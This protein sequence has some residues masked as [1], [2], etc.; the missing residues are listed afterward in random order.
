VEKIKT[1]YKNPEEMGSNP[2]C[3]NINFKQIK[4]TGQAGDLGRY[5]SYGSLQLPIAE[6]KYMESLPPQK[7]RLLVYMRIV[8]TF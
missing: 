6:A 4:S 8:K 3:F 7:E 1:C 5:I 2:D